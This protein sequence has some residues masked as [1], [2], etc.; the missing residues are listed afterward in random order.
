VKA[1]IYARI[2]FDKVGEGL[3]VER[4]LEDCRALIAAKGWTLA[5]EYVDNDISAYSGAKRPEFERM[6]ADRDAYDTVVVW[7]SDRLARRGRDLQRFLDTGATL[8]SCTE[9]EFTGSAGLLMLRILSGFAEHE[10][11][12]KSER[13]ARKMKDKAVR[14]D[15]HAGGPRAFGFTADGKDVIP[16]EAARLREAA[17]RVLAGETLTSILSDWTAQGVQ[18]P[19]GGRWSGSNVS[20]ALRS[21]R[22]IGMREYHGEL[23][24]GSW[25]TIL[26]RKV[27]ERLCATLGQVRKPHTGRRHLLTGLLICGRCGGHMTGSVEGSYSCLTKLQGG[28]GRCAIRASRIEPYVIERALARVPSFQAEP[29]DD[30]LLEQLAEAEADLAQL[31]KD[32]YVSKLISRPVFLAANGELEE[33]ID[34][35]RRQL[36]DP[37]SI[38]LDESIVEDWDTLSFGKR[39]AVLRAV[40]ERVVIVPGL[41]TRAPL[42]ER[43]VQMIFRD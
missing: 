43:R 11:G 33:R 21:P 15:P 14:G 42:D 31:S 38:Q 23:F 32:H 27:W 39:Q 13:I 18:T 4:Q 34:Q 6:L 9:P 24:D 41:G 2:S 22:M 19:K 20:R 8:T 26:D 29:V 16:E 10:S 5:D 17:Q 1:V 28:C 37:K 25:P 35:L 3:G 40:L 36:A 7:K 12:V 30:R